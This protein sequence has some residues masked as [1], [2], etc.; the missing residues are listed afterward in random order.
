MMLKPNPKADAAIDARIDAARG[1][2]D[3]QRHRWDAIYRAAAVAAA[4]AIRRRDF[5]AKRQSLAVLQQA[6]GYR[7][8]VLT[9]VFGAPIEVPAAYADLEL[10]GAELTRD[11]VSAALRVIEADKPTPRKP[12]VVPVTGKLVIID[13]PDRNGYGRARA[14][15]GRIV[16][17]KPYVFRAG[18]SVGQTIDSAEL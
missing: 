10:A 5:A 8:A 9:S 7:D 12:A 11:Q 16:N 6:G 3:G 13:G 1:R 4:A 15:D 18:R 17:V 2:A 14:S